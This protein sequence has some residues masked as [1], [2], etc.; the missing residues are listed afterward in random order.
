[1]VD[2]SISSFDSDDSTSL[3][4]QSLRKDGVVIIKNVLSSEVIDQLNA[5]LEPLFEGHQTGG[6]GS[7]GLL[8][9]KK[10]KP[11]APEE[12][13][14]D[15][16]EEE[17]EKDYWADVNFGRENFEEIVEFIERH[18]IDPE[19]NRSRGPIFTI[20]NYT[21]SAAPQRSRNRVGNGQSKIH[22]Y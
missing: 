17:E 2:K 15:E 1:M 6:S 9:A 8:V 13:K 4:L 12:E 22:R 19:I 18:Y 5:I 20:M 7:G 21:N 16:K 10:K 14:K 11:S 3:A